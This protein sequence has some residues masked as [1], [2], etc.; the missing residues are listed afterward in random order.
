MAA[1]AKRLVSSLASAG[2]RRSY[3]Y[4]EDGGP[5]RAVRLPDGRVVYVRA[6]LAAGPDHIV[7][8]DASGNVV[9][10]PLK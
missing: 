10:L 1:L 4:V 3:A 5:L 7:A 6:V 2:R 9:R 8:V